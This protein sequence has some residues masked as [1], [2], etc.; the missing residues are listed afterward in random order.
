MRLT[1]KIVWAIITA[2]NEQKTIEDIVKRTQKHVNQVLVVNDGSTDLTLPKAASGGATVVSN[3][4]SYGKGTSM[5]FGW[6]YLQNL[7]QLKSD[8]IIVTLDANQHNPDDIPKF[9]KALN[10]SEM[11][12]GE[13]DISNYPFIKRF[14]NK[15]LSSW[16]SLLSGQNIKDG[17]CGFRAFHYDIMLDL[18]KWVN[19]PSYEVE[20]QINIVTSLLKNKISFIP[21]NAP[22]E[23]GGTSIK[24][25]IRS[26]WYGLKT[27]IK[28]ILTKRGMW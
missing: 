17:E 28:F 20:M 25:G 3:V 21:I 27:W 7:Q 23:K 22:Y 13:R 1:N 2:K 11:V 8:D 19:A 24:T 9:I 26:F 10:N 15:L 12:I 5:K 18:L 4:I 14:G 6:W 16:A